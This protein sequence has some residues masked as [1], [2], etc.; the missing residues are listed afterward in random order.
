[1]SDPTTPDRPE[2]Q[3]AADDLSA[4]E[5][6]AETGSATDPK[7]VAA[8]ARASASHG[9]NRGAAAGMPAE[10]PQDLAGS[11]RRLARLMRPERGGAIVVIALAVASVT[12]TVLGPKVLGRATD[13]IFQGLAADGID[14]TRLH[15]I[16]LL[17][18][19]LYVVAWVLSYGQNY[20]LAGVVQRTMSRIRTDVEEKINRLPLGYV[21]RQPRGDLLS[22]VTN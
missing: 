5:T 3:P 15:N 20:L 16:L 14:F 10:K 1:M 7:T 11:T 8:E 13:V 18:A 17:A 19:G 4:L 21:D 22:R 9:P 12:L 6:D 2:E